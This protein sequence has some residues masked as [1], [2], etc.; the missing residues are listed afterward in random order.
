VRE[1]NLHQKPCEG[2]AVLDPSDFRVKVANA[3]SKIAETVRQ[4]RDGLGDDGEIGRGASPTSCATVESAG[5]VLDVLDV[6]HAESVAPSLASYDPDMSEP[7]ETAVK[8]LFAESRNTCFFTGC[9]DKLT[10]PKW[11]QV[12]AEIAHIK[13]E[14]PGSARYD[15]EQPDRERQGYENLMLLCPKHHKLV[16]R[17]EP[18]EYDVDRLQEMKARHLLDRQVG[19]QW[20]TEDEAERFARLA[21][22]FFR[23]Q[24]SLGLRIL[25]ARYGEQDT[26]ADV[27]KLVVNAV[28]DDSL[29]LAVE[30][31]TLGGDPLEN[32]VKRLDIEYEYNGLRQ[33]AT[34]AEHETAVLP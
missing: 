10:D 28:V 33:T 21:L 6:G 1:E 2:S 7:S 17:L 30:N 19:E 13:G 3:V 15:A 11:K 27:L 23:E 26:F 14:R 24:H 32:V 16:D 34:F 18:D 20:C 25:S 29:S 22:D 12:N 31:D 4:V 5:V 8:T 9:E